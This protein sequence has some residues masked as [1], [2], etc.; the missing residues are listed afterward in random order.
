MNEIIVEAE[1]PKREVSVSGGEMMGE[2][3]SKEMGCR[4]YIYILSLSHIYL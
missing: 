2:D 1:N 3:G 4:R